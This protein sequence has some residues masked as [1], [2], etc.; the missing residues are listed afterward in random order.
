MMRI[1][2]WGQIL[3]P[4]VRTLPL[5]LINGDCNVMVSGSRIKVGVHVHMHTSQRL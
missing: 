2:K 3:V 1:N 5:I 4:V